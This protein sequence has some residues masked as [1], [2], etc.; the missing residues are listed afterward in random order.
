MTLKAKKDYLEETHHTT[1]TAFSVK[2]VCAVAQEERT[3]GGKPKMGFIHIRKY[4]L[5]TGSG[6][7]KRKNVWEGVA[8]IVA[9]YAFFKA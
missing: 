7:D 6:Q 8:A 5:V 2:R 1:L 4:R 9:N 3:T